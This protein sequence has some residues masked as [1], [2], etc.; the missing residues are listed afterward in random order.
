MTLATL[1][2]LMHLRRQQVEGPSQFENS[3]MKPKQQIESSVF[4]Q[5]I[6][7]VESEPITWIYIPPPGL[8]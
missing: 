5:F 6:V 7:D 2:L 4:Q 8:H 3:L 1:A